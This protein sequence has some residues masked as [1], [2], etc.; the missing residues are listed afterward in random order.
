MHGTVSI[1]QLHTNFM[2]LWP[3]AANPP[4]HNIRGEFSLQVADIKSAQQWNQ[5]IENLPGAHVLQ[6]WQWG[7]VKSQ[8]GWDVHPLIWRDGSDKVTAAALVLER[9]IS[10]KLLTWRLSV[11]YVPRGPLLDWSNSALVQRVLSDLKQFAAEQSAIFIKIDPDLPIGYGIPGESQAQEDQIGQETRKTLASTGW[12]FSDEQIQFRN[13]VAL[14]LRPDEEDLLKRMKSKTRYNIRLAQRRGVTVRSGTVDDI[15][16]LYHMYA[17]TAVRDDFLIRNQAYYQTVWQTFFK[18]DLAKPLIAE[19][20]N[21]P[22]GAV[23][24]FR[25]AGRAWYLSLIH[26]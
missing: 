2:S 8:F 11:I 26:I 9:K 23:V 4:Q 17:H 13:T 20:E 12:I 15:D 6:T 1:V 24:I 3:T 18:A 5:L 10:N 19:V 21:Q 7:E 16:L 14:D 25:F 22:V